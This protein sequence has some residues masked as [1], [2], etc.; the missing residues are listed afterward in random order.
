MRIELNIAPVSKG[1]P[2]F[3]TYT[4]RTYTDNKTREFEET[5]G[6]LYK[7]KGG[8]Y[9]DNK[10]IKVKLEFIEK[11]PKSYSKNKTDEALKGILRPTKR[12]IDNYI[13]SVL[14]GLLEVA[15]VDDRYICNLEASKRFGLEDKIIIEIEEV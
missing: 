13:K 8:E 1:R 10:F 4:G 9:F 15:Y 3:N 6:Y 12:D 2:R 14:D 7:L 5:V 11:V